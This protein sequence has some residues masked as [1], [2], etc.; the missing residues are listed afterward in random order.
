[1]TKS[2]LVEA[3]ATEL[4]TTKK[5]AEEAIDALVEIVERTV[6]GGEKVTLSGFGT[7]ER[8]MRG[9]R[10]G[11]NPQ[12]HEEIMIPDMLMPHFRAGS[13]FKARLR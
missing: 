8:A 11:V 1:M 10:R 7:F 9:G 4:N 6:A 12:T 2:E 3:M 5:H 13:R